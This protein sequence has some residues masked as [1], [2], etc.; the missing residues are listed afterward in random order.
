MPDE[1]LFKLAGERR[2]R[3]TLAAQIDRMLKDPRSA[4][5][6]RNFSGQWLQARDIAPVPI[7]SLDIFLRENPNPALD[8]A[9]DTFRSI[10]PIAEDKRT[11]EQA[12]DF[13]E[14]R[15]VFR[16]FRRMP[17]P[18]LNDKLRAAM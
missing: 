3:A 18:D 7:N 8:K 10:I 13:V 2:L 9:R 15:R 11:P 16:E 17:K 6:V 1:E 4:E 12:A 14:A 5:F